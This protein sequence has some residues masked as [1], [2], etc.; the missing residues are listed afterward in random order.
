MNALQLILDKV[1]AGQKP[2]Y[3]K[4]EPKQVNRKRRI[5]KTVDKLL[6]EPKIKAKPVVFGSRSDGSYTK[7]DHEEPKYRRV[8]R[9]RSQRINRRGR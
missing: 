6:K 8:M 3:V 2:V 5:K 4:T 1:K 7:Q 9:R